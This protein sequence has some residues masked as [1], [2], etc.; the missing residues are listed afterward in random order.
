MRRLLLEKD[1]LRP[2]YGRKAG[3]GHVAVVD[4]KSAST[5]KEMVLMCHG[6]FPNNGFGGCG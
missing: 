6:L 5:I 2:C 3:D 1:V 4:D